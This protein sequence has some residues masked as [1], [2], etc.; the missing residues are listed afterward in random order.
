M[1]SS[2]PRPDGAVAGLLVLA[3]G[4]RIYHN[5]DPQEFIEQAEKERGFWVWLAEV[6]STHPNLPKRVKAISYI[7]S[8]NDLSPMSLEVAAGNE[9][10]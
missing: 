3:A 6:L 4:K 2:L 1:N 7:I 10:L 8:K 5:V 9:K